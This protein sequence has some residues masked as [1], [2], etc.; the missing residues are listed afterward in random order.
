M[1]N[2]LVVLIVDDNPININIMQVLLTQENVTVFDTLSG[3]D[4]LKIAANTK[5]DLVLLDVLLPGINGYEVCRTIKGNPEFKNTMVIMLSTVLKESEHIAEAL[6]SGAD[7]FIGRPVSNRE[8]TARLSSALKMIHTEK[9]LLEREL[10][11]RTLINAMPDIVC[12]KDGE[13]KWLT[14]N[15]FDLKLFQLEGVDYVGKTDSELAQYSTFYKDAFLACE[16][17]DEIAWKKGVASRA[18]EVIPLPDGTEKTF[19][20]IKIPTFTETGER[21]GL[22]VV[23]RDITERKKAGNQ[24]RQKIEELELFNNLT[25]DRELKMIELKQEINTLL[26]L[27]GKPAKYTIS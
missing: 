7:A 19:D 21:N 22:I 23:G 11:L 27:S 17:S 5:P 26:K 20:I 2:P 6:E 24:L 12:F 1:D 25:I 10:H 13:G 9:A 4:A 18:D 15:D 16:E 8:L 3:E 14:A